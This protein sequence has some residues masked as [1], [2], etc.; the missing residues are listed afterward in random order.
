MGLADDILST[1][2]GFKFLIQFIG[3][4]ILILF[5]LHIEIFESTI[6]NYTLTVFWF[7]GVM[8]SINMLDNMDA[9]TTSVGITILIGAITILSVLGMGSSPLFL[10]SIGGL[11]GLTSFLFVNWNPSKMYMGDNGSQFLGALLAIIGIQLFW[12][13]ST[14]GTEHPISYAFLIAFLAFIVPITDTTTV[15]INRLLRKQSP[16]IGGRDHTTHHLSYLGLS[17]RM[18][19]IILL[20]INGVGVLLAT[21]LLLHPEK[22]SIPLWVIGLFSITIF[23]MLY[24]N[25]KISKPK[26]K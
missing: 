21:F 17:D 3:A 15:T 16:F 22:I 19:A 4:I 7:V 6:L 12:N 14:V 11:A 20:C 10:V 2:P 26:T 24:A 18:V 1:P 23:G 13:G 8:N 25:T 9:I 5:D